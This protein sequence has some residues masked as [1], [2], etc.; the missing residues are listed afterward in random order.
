[1]IQVMQLKEKKSRLT[2]KNEKKA[3]VGGIFDEKRR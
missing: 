1:M 2:N 3:S